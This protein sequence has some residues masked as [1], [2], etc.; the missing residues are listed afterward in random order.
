MI[1]RVT[2]VFHFT[3][4]DVS[5]ANCVA[6]GKPLGTVEVLDEDQDR[7]S[8]ADTETEAREQIQELIEED[9]GNGGTTTVEYDV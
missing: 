7:Y 1:V 3:I 8:F 5:E 6:F 2:K 9:D 4:Q